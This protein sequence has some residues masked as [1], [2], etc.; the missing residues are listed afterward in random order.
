MYYISDMRKFIKTK[1][2]LDG[3][4]KHLGV[5]NVDY[6]KQNKSLT[7]RNGAQ[8]EIIRT[9]SNDG[10]LLFEYELILES[11]LPLLRKESYFKNM[12]ITDAID[13]KYEIGEVSLVTVFGKV[14]LPCGTIPGQ[15]QRVR[16]PVKCEIIR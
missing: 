13:I 9:S 1:V 11:L 4:F 7:K 5:E 8:Y 14:K 2:D 12:D 16:I 15:R 10:T 3:F 6:I